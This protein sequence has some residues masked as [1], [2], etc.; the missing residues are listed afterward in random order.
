MPAV[1]AGV[2]MSILMRS[3]THRAQPDRPAHAPYGSILMR[4]S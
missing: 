3:G 1:E 2:E 4:F